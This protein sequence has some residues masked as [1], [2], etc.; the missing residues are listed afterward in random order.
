[1]T[2]YNYASFPLDMEMPDFEAV[3]ARFGDD[4]VFVGLDRSSSDDGAR[5]LI[6]ATGIYFERVVRN[7]QSCPALRVV[8]EN[9]YGKE[10]R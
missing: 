9:G 2:E 7:T 3:H 10:K 1:M 4:V 6:E 8:E 5:A